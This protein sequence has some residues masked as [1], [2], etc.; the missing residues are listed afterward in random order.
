MTAAIGVL[1]ARVRLEEKQLMAAFAEAGAPAMPLPAAG[2]P[3]PIGRVPSSPSF[4]P[5]SNG[6]GPRVIVD[7]CQD[8]AVAAA[9]LPV[10]RVL[11][12]NTVDA[13]LAATGDRLAVAAAL[14]AAGVTRPATSLIC[15]EAAA[16]A[17][18]DEVGYPATLLP[19]HPGAV[20]TSLLDRDVA[21]AVVEHRAV[22]GDAAAALA[23]VQAGAPTM[24]ERLTVVVVDGRATALI[25]SNPDAGWTRHR[26]DA[27]ALAEET[28][29]ALGAGVVGVEVAL[30]SEGIVVWDVQPVPE[31][32]G[33]APLGRTTV[34]EALATLTLR[35]LE[36]DREVELAAAR[37]DG[38]AAGSGW[39]ELL[40][41]RLDAGTSS[42]RRRGV[43][44]GVALSA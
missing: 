36:T 39:G 25:E 16:L 43:S 44:D 33:A 26:L 34:A 23:L 27:V 41:Q 14:T 1:C 11:G 38:V 3:L 35:R 32:R 6:T 18:L 8:R 17:A 28:A 24:A 7:R 21:E 40:W 12:A 15:S 4:A 29:N 31:F 37:E 19:L 20:P 9:V 42:G 2:A 22:L 13:G 30:A 10:C 5:A